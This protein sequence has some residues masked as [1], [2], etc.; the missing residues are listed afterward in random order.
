VT[1]D[2]G[3]HA[4]DDQGHHHGRGRSRR[5][6]VVVLVLTA[7]F[8]V[9]EFAAGLFTNS[10]ALLSDAGHMLTDVGALALSLFALWF[11]ARPATARKS[12][13]FHR[14]E[15]LAALANGAAVV[16]IAVFIVL[17]ALERIG[18]PP[19]VKSGPMLVV[20]AAGLLV[21]VTAAFILHGHSTESLNVRGA[22]L[23]VLGDAAGSVGAIAAAVLMLTTG[24]ALADPIASL[25]VAG[26]I[27]FS[28]WAL[29]RQA[30]D[31]LLEG[32]PAHLDLEVI[33][34]ALRGVPG[35]TEVHDLHVWTITSGFE[36]LTAH[37]VLAPGARHQEV[38]KAAH[39]MLG[40]RFGLTHSTLQPEETGLNPCGGPPASGPCGRC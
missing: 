29:I 15:I 13:G 25:L 40:A 11:S 21:N 7:A 10:L 22:F 17:E 14:A 27:V 19:D 3:G 34:T 12:F 39:G 9:V 38:L 20:A 4:H 28:A 1:H 5:A 6:L 35:V 24:F 23:H 32:T 16:V 36:S 26:L 31:V 37:L 8:M 33:R 18:A 30:L 2:H